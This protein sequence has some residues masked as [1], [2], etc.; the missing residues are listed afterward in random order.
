ME[1]RNFKL[2]NKK[3]VLTKCATHVIC[4]VTA[5]PIFYHLFITFQQTLLKE[6]AWFKP[7]SKVIQLFSMIKVVTVLQQKK[8]FLI[9]HKMEIL[10]SSLMFDLQSIDWQVS[11]H[12]H[13]H[14]HHPHHLSKLAKQNLPL[15]NNLIALKN[16]LRSKNRLN[17]MKLCWLE[18]LCSSCCEIK[19]INK[20]IKIQT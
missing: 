12:F 5:S 17:Y 16:W 9:S 10:G 14:F 1:L 13:N 19:L 4:T 8:N 7:G 20:Y 6:T 18:I 3:S 2:E 15:K 11:R